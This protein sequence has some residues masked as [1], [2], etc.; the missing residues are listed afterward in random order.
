MWRGGRRV[1]SAAELAAHEVGEPVG[2]A[3]AEH[4]SPVEGADPQHRFDEWLGQRTAVHDQG[5]EQ[6]T[7]RLDCGQYDLLQVHW[8]DRSRDRPRRNHDRH[9][10]G[11]CA[12]DAEEDQQQLVVPGQVAPVVAQV[13]QHAA[14]ERLMVGNGRF[15]HGKDSS[16]LN[17]FILYHLFTI[18]SI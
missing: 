12:E 3:D 17:R 15:L 11:P 5:L 16:G 7:D 1:R 8:L 18:M 6:G 10:Q 13:V 14:A 4:E 9:D 2:A